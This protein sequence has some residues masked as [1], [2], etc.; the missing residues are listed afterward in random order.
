MGKLRK[1]IFGKAAILAGASIGMMSLLMPKLSEAAERSA[2]VANEDLITTSGSA[3]IKVRPDSMR[4]DLGVRV[5]AKTLSEARN[6][7]ARRMRRLTKAIA[8][9]DVKGLSV[10]TSQLD[11]SPI[12]TEAKEGRPSRIV[13]YRAES[14]LHLRLEG[15]A[16]EQLGDV[17]ARIIDAGVRAGANR[18]EGVSFYLANPEPEQAR[19]LKLAVKKAE[20]QA[21]VMAE[22]AGVRL[23]AVQSLDGSP[24]HRQYAFK[25]MAMAVALEAGGGAPTPIE[26]GE[27]TISA[28]VSVKYHIQ[29]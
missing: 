3:E 1:I 9:L 27:I 12:E 8:D 23:G 29:R 25:R 17:S 26:P 22:A 2:E 15:V 24:E 14:S 5:E 7:L 16:L 4:T 10:R 6:D 11:I 21:R 18:V 19:A 20:A 13:G 28:E